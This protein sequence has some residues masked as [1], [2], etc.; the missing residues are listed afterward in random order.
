M[1]ELIRVLVADD[2]YVVRQPARKRSS[3]RLPCSLMS[4]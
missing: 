2:H 3:W 4:S 1:I